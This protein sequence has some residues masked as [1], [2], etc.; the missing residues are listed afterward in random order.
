[1]NDIYG[2]SELRS[3]EASAKAARGSEARGRLAGEVIDT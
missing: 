2:S 3:A 1:M